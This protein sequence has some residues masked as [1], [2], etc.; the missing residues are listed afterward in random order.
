MG[1]LLAGRRLAAGRGGTPP[2]RAS[3][4]WRGRGEAAQMAACAPPPQE[5]L[6]PL[7]PLPSTAGG[8]CQGQC[9]GKGRGEA[10]SCQHD[11]QDLGAG[12]NSSQQDLGAPIASALRD[13][14]PFPIQALSTFI[15][16]VPA[17]S[18]AR[19][20]WPHPSC[21]WCGACSPAG[22]T[23]PW[24]HPIAFLMLQSHMASCK[25]HT[26]AKDLFTLGREQ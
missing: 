18:T 2:G 12:S 6:A 10:G 13:A 23:A 5:A 4:S 20:N 9:W 14:A 7:L 16:G 15:T 19:L 25:I 17:L 1:C 8:L 26:L 3:K 21:A 22:H 11:L 24:S